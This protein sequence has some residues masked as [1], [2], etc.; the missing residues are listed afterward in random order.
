MRRRRSRGAVDVTLVLKQLPERP[1]LMPTTITQ[2]YASEKQASDAVA[3]L[4]KVVR[5]DRIKLERRRLGNT[6]VTVEAEPDKAITALQILNE[7][8]PAAPPPS[9]IRNNPTPLSSLLHLPV[10]WNHEPRV[11]LIDDPAPLSRF[12]GLRTLIKD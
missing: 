7:S 6:S 3:A 2:F 11:T 5:D 4:K 1:T 12:L 9:G 10:L 8:S